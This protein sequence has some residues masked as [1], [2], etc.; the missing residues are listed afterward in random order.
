MH[1]HHAHEHAHAGLTGSLIADHET[2]LTA[3]DRLELRLSEMKRRGAVDV[4]TFNKFLIFARSFIDKCH[5]GKEERCLFPCLERRGIPREGG[6]IG[7]M[8]YEHELGRKLVWELDELLRSYSEGKATPE[9]I[10]SKC[11]EY[12]QL[13][14]QHIAKENNVLFPAGESAAGREDVREVT[15]CYEVIE[16]KEVGHEV[17]GELERLA[18]EL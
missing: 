13:L 4:E 14:R 15:E 2:I 5:H 11:E 6:P 16:G 18:K 8:L 17:H 9:T 3:L 7:V 1:P 10:F 12:I